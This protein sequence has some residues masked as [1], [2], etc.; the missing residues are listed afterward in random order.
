MSFGYKEK[1]ITVKAYLNKRVAPRER[2]EN[3]KFGNEIKHL[4]YQL[5]Y[6]V[7]YN[8]SNTH[9]K[10]IH[11]TRF[12]FID[13]PYF[14]NGDPEEIIAFEKRNIEKIIR[15]H[16][17]KEQDYK[18]K[19]LSKIYQEYTESLHDI[20]NFKLKKFIVTKF[21]LA[22]NQFY[23]SFFNYKAADI[24][25]HFVFNVI[26]KL[27]DVKSVFTEEEI[28][29]IENLKNFDF[30]YMMDRGIGHGDKYNLENQ[31]I[32]YRPGYSDKYPT[33]IDWITGDAQNEIKRII[34]YNKELKNIK[35]DDLI[36]DISWIM[37]LTQ[38]MKP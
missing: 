26:Q 8:K 3:D 14:E 24:S 36:N 18:V 4:A 28:R 25:S 1:K 34:H 19:G 11:G 2:T 21:G 9:L 15:Y 22:T 20:V 16:E 7:I 12:A 13:K 27:G 32:I 5:Y 38:A 30:A 6:Q 10:S 17:S 37:E 33:K 29:K 23:F 31:N 35:P